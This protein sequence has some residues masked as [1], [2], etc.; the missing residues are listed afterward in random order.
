MW[1]LTVHILSHLL[2]GSFSKKVEAPVAVAEPARD[3]TRSIY[4][5]PV[6]NPYGAPPPGQ[7]YLEHRKRFRKGINLSLCEIHLGS[8]L[9]LVLVNS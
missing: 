7:P 5:D 8:S 4:Y 3:P 6:L 1:T 9:T 2:R